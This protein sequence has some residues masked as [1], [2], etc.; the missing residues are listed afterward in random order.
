M[1]KLGLS[2]KQEELLRKLYVERG[3]KL[4]PNVEEWI[5]NLP[6]QEASVY[7]DKWITKLRN[8]RTYGQWGK[9]K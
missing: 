8:K 5:R 2:P 1:P 4:T 7:I 9:R 6:A 3:K